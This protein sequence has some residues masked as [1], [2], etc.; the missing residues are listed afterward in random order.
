M[1]KSKKEMAEAV[2]E[3]REAKIVKSIENFEKKCFDAIKEAIEAG[4]LQTEVD[5]CDDDFLAMDCVTEVLRGIGIKYCLI[6]VQDENEYVLSHRFRLSV[7][8]MVDA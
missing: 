6:E 8:Y 1:F 4:N 7:A 3:N 2:K 5:L